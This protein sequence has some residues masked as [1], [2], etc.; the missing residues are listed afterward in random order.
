MKKYQ[1][2]QTLEVLQ[3]ANNYNQW[4]ADTFLAHLQ[5]PVLE[6]GAGTGNLSKHFK[7][8][9]P[10]TMSDSDKSL[11]VFLKKKFRH[12]D[13]VTYAH[14]DVTKKSPAKYQQSFSSVLGINVLEHIED[15]IL[16]LSNI[17][18]MLKRKGKLLLLVPA[19]QIAYTRFDKSLGHYRRYEKEEL[20]KKI[21]EAKFVIDELYFFNF[22]GLLSWVIRDKVERKHIHMK[23]YQVKLFD[24]I[25]P[26]IR[27]IEGV[28]KP[29]IGVS[30]ILIAHK[31]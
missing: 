26:I 7:H 27:K 16:A 22:I 13:G 19:K 20:K 12:H 1:G 14:I 6:I 4:I 10:Y 29:P 28:Q 18:T 23:P 25:V 21:E 3:F 15:D 24:W 9:T 30:L 5:S 11:V 17:H 2:V 31:K 8:V